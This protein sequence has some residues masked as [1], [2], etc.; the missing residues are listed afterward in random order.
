MTEPRCPECGG[1][2]IYVRELSWIYWN[3]TDVDYGAYDSTGIC[4]D[5]IWAYDQDRKADGSMDDRFGCEDCGW[6]SPVSPESRRL[7]MG[8]EEKVE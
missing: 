6:E 5:G 3:L 2:K 4:D 8:E 1:S 7:L